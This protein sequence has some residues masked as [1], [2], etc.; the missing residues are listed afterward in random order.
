MT[1]FALL[2]LFFFPPS[3]ALP[4]LNVYLSAYV[5]FPQIPHF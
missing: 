5:A 3:L 1:L 4:P 2:L